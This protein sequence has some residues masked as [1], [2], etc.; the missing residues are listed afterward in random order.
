MKAVKWQNQDWSS[1]GLA[2][3]S[4]FLSCKLKCYQKI[5]RKSGKLLLTTQKVLKNETKPQ[6]GLR[7]IYPKKFLKGEPMENMTCIY[8]FIYLFQISSFRD[9]RKNFRREFISSFL[10]QVASLSRISELRFPKY[11]VRA[12]LQI[13]VL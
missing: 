13:E 2:P 1:K 5:N 6:K 4:P 11:G 9:L 7:S 12:L 10:I 3:E 8:L